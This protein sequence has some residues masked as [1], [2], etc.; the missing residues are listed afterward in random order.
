MSGW[1]LVVHHCLLSPH[2][3]LIVELHRTSSVDVRLHFLRWAWKD[4]P[5][6]S[7]QWT[8]IFKVISYTLNKVGIARLS[9]FE[10]K[11]CIHSSTHVAKSTAKPL[12]SAKVPSLSPLSW[13]NRGL[14]V[15]LV[16]QWTGNF[17]FGT[18]FVLLLYTA[19][20]TFQ[21]IKIER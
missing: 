7:F 18:S 19:G 15:S 20:L 9:D 3:S 8:R 10:N 13:C 21:Y 12:P 4:M 1:W 2:F 6:I 11:K 17:I 5:E 14:W 16:L